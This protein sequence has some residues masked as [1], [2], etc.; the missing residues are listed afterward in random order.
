MFETAQVIIKY[1][2]DSKDPFIQTFINGLTLGLKIKNPYITK[3]F[4]NQYNE[5]LD[6]IWESEMDDPKQYQS[7]KPFKFIVHNLTKDDFYDEFK[8]E[9]VSSSLITDKAMCVCGKNKLGF[10]L[11]PYNI[12]AAVPY[13]LYTIN[14][15]FQPS[16]H[17]KDYENRE[18]DK[19]FKY[20]GALLSPEI[21]EKEIINQTVE[22]NGEILNNDNNKVFSEVIIDGWCPTAI[23]TI[24]NGEQEINPDYRRA[25]NLNNIYMFTFID[26]DKSLYR[27]KNGLEPLTKQDQIA[28]ANNLFEYTNT[29][30]ENI[31]KLYLKIYKLF[32]KLKENNEYTTD[33]F[34]HE[35]QKIK[36]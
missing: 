31:E 20:P 29:S 27:S 23:Y 28:L 21:I 24:T 10:I 3:K 36:K 16:F 4:I 5:Y 11:A 19:A 15:Y 7:G 2:A 32:L 1:N 25:Q 34:V 33:R 9:L 30:V 13:D 14:D 17:Y 22:K 8:T 12:K 6:K 35:F 26:I 18:Y